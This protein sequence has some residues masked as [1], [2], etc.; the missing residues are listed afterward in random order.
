MIKI[1]QPDD[2]VVVSLGI[3]LA[4]KLQPPG[5]RDA[6]LLAA[7]LY[8]CRLPRVIGGVL[9]VAVIWAAVLGVLVWWLYRSISGA[10]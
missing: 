5:L 4:V 2:L 3:T 7:D 6:M 10:V 8:Q 1:G 9:L